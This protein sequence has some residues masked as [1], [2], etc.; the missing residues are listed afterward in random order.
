MILGMPPVRLIHAEG[1]I[2]LNGP[3]HGIIIRYPKPTHQPM[4]GT[5]PPVANVQ[6]KTSGL[7]V[8]SLVLGILGL[9]LLLGCIGVL[10]AIPAVICGHIAQSRIKR[11]AGLLSGSGMALA[12]LITGYISIALG[13]FLVPMMMAIAIPNFVKARDTAMRNGCINNLRQIDGA[14]ELW[15]ME[16]QKDADAVPTEADLDSVLKDKKMS[17]LK[18]GKQGTYSINSV[19]QLPTCSVPTHELLK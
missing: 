2:P 16:N 9:V 11:S 13:I 5:P 7:A 18:C 10:I 4:N 12:G 1:R 6:P 19:G 14:K 8:T 15:A 3:G 17:E